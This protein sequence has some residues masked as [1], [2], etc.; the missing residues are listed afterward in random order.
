MLIYITGCARSG[1]TLLQQLMSAFELTHVV[2]GEC[3][4]DAFTHPTIRKLSNSHHII[5]K[6]SGECLGGEYP[7][8]INGKNKKQVTGYLGKLLE[9]IRSLNLRIVDIMRDPRD[10]LTSRH[11]SKPDSY[12]VS[13]QRLFNHEWE[14]NWLR[15][16]WDKVLSIKYEDLLTNPDICQETIAT[17]TGLEAEAKFSDYPDFL[18]DRKNILDIEEKAMAGIRKLDPERIGRWKKN[19]DSRDYI[20]KLAKKKSRLN[21][22]LVKHGYETDKEWFGNIQV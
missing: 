14:I 20:I 19:D 17:N 15:E 6:R 9:L 4:V 8:G 3:F 16:R 21:E 1:T 22:L 10:V 18:S 13:L 5:I 7:Q 11:H 12:Y 2:G